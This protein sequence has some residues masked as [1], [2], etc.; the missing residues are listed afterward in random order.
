MRTRAVDV[1][2]VEQ[3]AKLSERLRVGFDLLS[4]IAVSVCVPRPRVELV[5]LLQSH[6][7]SSVV[8]DGKY[9]I[10]IT[11]SIKHESRGG[12]EG[13]M[14]SKSWKTDLLLWLMAGSFMIVFFMV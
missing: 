7:T 6:V 10:Y 13:G 2:E 12:G 5:G 8:D 4:V 14:K 11:R 1:V 3:S 9:H